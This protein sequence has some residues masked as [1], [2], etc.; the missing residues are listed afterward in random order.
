ME[1][2]EQKSIMELMK[3][4]KTLLDERDSLMQRVDRDRE[5]ETGEC[6]PLPKENS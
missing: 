3:D 2:T 1:L 6:D 4:L 5:M